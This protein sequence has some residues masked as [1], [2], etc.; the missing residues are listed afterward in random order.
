MNVETGGND[1]LLNLFYL[2]HSKH[3]DNTMYLTGVI[4]YGILTKNQK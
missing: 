3:L 2:E 4:V 1:E